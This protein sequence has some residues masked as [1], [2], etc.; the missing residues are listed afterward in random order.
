MTKFQRGQIWLVNF[1]PS[2]GHEY[3]KVRPALI[4][5]ND[6]YIESGELLT[7][8]PISSQISKQTELDILLIKDSQNRLM[9]DSLLKIKQISSF[10][11]RRFIKLVGIVN[12]GI[13]TN[14]KESINQVI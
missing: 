3:K 11:K 5:Q 10:D 2:F 8:I 1:D 9:I 14:V 4:I 12:E 6:K 13:M 7:V